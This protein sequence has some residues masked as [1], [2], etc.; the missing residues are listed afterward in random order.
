MMTTIIITTSLPTVHGGLRQK[1]LKKKDTDRRHH[2]SKFLFFFVP[3]RPCWR[4]DIDFQYRG[5]ED[6]VVTQDS[7]MTFFS[8]AKPMSCRCWQFLIPFGTGVAVKV[9]RGELVRGERFIYSWELGISVRCSVGEKIVAIVMDV[10][11]I[12]SLISQVSTD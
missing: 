3:Q 11:I 4:S 10:I 7:Y 6:A 8:A 9:C 12:T 2:R 5:G 1:L